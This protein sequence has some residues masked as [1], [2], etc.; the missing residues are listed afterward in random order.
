MSLF[1]R[2]DSPNWW[3]KLTPRNGR[4]IQ[5]STGTPDKVKA[6][7][8]HDKLK[9][10]LW[11]QE[12]L[13]IKPSRTWREAVVRWLEETSE[14]ATH[15][16]DKKKLIWLHFF[17]GDRALDQITSDVIDQIRSAKLKEASKGTVNRYLA[18]VRAILI[19]SRDEWEWVDKV[20]KIRLFKETTSRERSLTHE[21]AR[22][23]LD[24]LPE[25]QRELVLFSLATGLRQSNVLRLGWEQVNLELRHAWV[26]GT[27]SK[28]RRPISVP[29]NDVALAVLKRQEG[30]HSI[31]VFTYQGKPINSANTKAWTTAL[32][33]AGI[34][35]FRWHDLR[36]TWATWQRQAGTPTHE[37]QRLGGWR[38]GAMVERY[39]HLAP[40]YLAV[41]ASRLDSVLAGYDLATRGT[42]EKRPASLEAA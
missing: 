24:E 6:E 19:R 35:D 13:G 25:H 1:K 36:H 42:N 30:K 31:R 2:K 38:T 4:P 21:Q 12:R 8:F 32:T 18:L 28:N 17:L 22:R 26:K 16:E 39:A 29:L 3:V 40:E 20:P 33:R 23:L 9:A 37:L 41:A 11:D 15:K 34:D 5:Q 10:S 7:E 27:Q 14:K